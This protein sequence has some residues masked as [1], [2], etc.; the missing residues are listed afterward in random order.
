MRVN[1]LLNLIRIPWGMGPLRH[2]S[3]LPRCRIPRG[4]PKYIHNQFQPLHTL[5]SRGREGTN[6]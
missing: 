3:L 4:L 2:P 1:H 5:V 6:S